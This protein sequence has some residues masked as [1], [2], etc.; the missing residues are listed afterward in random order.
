MENKRLILPGKFPLI[1]WSSRFWQKNLTFSLVILILIACTSVNPSSLD[2]Q[3]NETKPTSQMALSINEQD[4][5][6]QDYTSQ[7]PIQNQDFGTIYLPVINST[8]GW[9]TCSESSF[10][11]MLVDSSPGDWISPA[12]TMIFANDELAIEGLVATGSPSEKV[13]DEWFVNLPGWTR[14][15]IRGTYDQLIPIYS[16]ATIF[17]MQNMYECIG[18][19][20]ESVHQ[21]GQE[22]LEPLIW[23]PK[24]KEVAETTGKCLIYGPA[25]LD[26][27]RLATP[28]GE[29]EPNDELLADLI[30]QVAPNV[31]IWMVQLAKYQRWTDG[32]RDDKGNEFNIEDFIEWINWWNTQIKT[33]NPDAKVW[34]QLGIGKFDPIL[35]V[36]LPPQP[37]EYILN[38]R[39]S[40]IQAGIDGTFVMPSQ[41][42]QNSANPQ[43]RAYYLESLEMLKQAMMA[44]CGP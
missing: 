9:T 42:C 30:A 33:A 41:S 5:I 34:S 8:G 1:S 13:R 36:C 22:A 12:E 15:F 35:N 17:G 31:D 11:T 28:P 16:T 10:G 39:E 44:A 18:Y 25:V 14:S 27:E 19:G 6:F 43:D 26:Y 20:P 40:L 3:S 32:G 37:P 2:L 38:Y 24:A 29:S 4:A 21:A 7:P 23:V